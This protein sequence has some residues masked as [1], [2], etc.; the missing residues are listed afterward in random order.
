MAAYRQKSLWSKSVHSLENVQDAKILVIVAKRTIIVWIWFSPSV[1]SFITSWHR[2][3]EDYK[4][5]LAKACRRTGLG[6]S[7]AVQTPSRLWGEVYGLQHTSA[8]W[9]G[10]LQFFSRWPG[11]RA[12]RPLHTWL[13]TGQDSSCLRLPVVNRLLVYS[14]SAG[15]RLIRCR[16]T[17]LPNQIAWH[18][19]PVIFGKGTAV[20]NKV[21]LPGLRFKH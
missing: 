6:S 16:W 15:R 21:W 3:S 13:N 1:N 9:N 20:F 7:R 12:S 8:R 14:N 17:K 18:A 11:L 19:C 5:Q 4:L 2:R 10:N